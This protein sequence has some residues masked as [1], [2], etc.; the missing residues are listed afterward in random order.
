MEKPRKYSKMILETGNIV[1]E[2]NN[3]FNGLIA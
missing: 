2:M 3:A 1:A